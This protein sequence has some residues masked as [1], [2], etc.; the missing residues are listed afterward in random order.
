MGWI[1]TREMNI[2]IKTLLH[3]FSFQRVIL[4][5]MTS[6]TIGFHLSGV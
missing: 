3:G 4:E 2:M 1:G 5:I 6:M